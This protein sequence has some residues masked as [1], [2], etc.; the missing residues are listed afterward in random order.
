MSQRIAV[1]TGGA[2][3][4]GE[5][6]A[7]RLAKAGD[8]VIVADVHEALGAQVAADIVRGGGQ[9]AFLA[10]DVASEA[11]VVTLGELIASRHG[12]VGALVNSA[13]VLQMPAP[14][15]EYPLADHDRLWQINYRGTYLCCREFGPRMAQAGRGSIV[16]IASVIGPYRAAPLLAYAPA[17]AAIPA[18]TALLAGEF[19]PANVRVNAVAPGTTLTPPNRHRFETGLRDPAVWTRPSCLNRIAMPEEIAEGVHFLASDAASA[20]TGV[21]LP[22]DCGW[23]A[24]EA[25]APYGGLRHA[26]PRGPGQ[27]Q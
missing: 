4:I 7:R 6:C 9:A 19:G 3:G 16:N 12:T 8:F 18:L 1:I 23:L 21:T 13:G 24:G 22:I 25:W 10:L 11:S 2:S 14:I 17:K 26:E 27:R 5:A 15:T 20:I